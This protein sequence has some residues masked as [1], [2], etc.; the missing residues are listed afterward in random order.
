ME[1]LVLS[2]PSTKDQWQGQET[3]RDP[4]GL[5]HGA[6]LSTSQ[7]PSFICTSDDV[8]RIHC[9]GSHAR[10]A[11]RGRRR[12]DSVTVP[13]AFAVKIQKWK[14]SKCPSAEIETRRTV[15]HHKGLK[16]EAADLEGSSGHT[17]D[18]DSQNNICSVATSAL[19]YIHTSTW[20]QPG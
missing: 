13:G 3:V 20:R 12:R 4:L 10:H 2:T 9:C 5:W 6:H 16:N 7:F 17:V 11:R 19:K 15:D 18:T 8:S 1:L 14:Q